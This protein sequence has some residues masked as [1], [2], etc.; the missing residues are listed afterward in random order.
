MKILVSILN[1]NACEHVSKQ[2]PCNH[3]VI[4]SHKLTGSE[5]LEEPGAS[6]AAGEVGGGLSGVEGSDRLHISLTV[7]CGGDLKHRYDSALVQHSI[8]S[9][10]L[11]KT[12]LAAAYASLQ[13]ETLHQ[14]QIWIR[15][16]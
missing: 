9:Q 15:Y 7:S 11:S 4:R 2:V 6:G 5:G 10:H 8:R 3:S 12:L 16:G 13:V 1:T 14:L